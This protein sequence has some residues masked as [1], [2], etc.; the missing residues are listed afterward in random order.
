M[1]GFRP[2]V[3][4]F[5]FA[6]PFLV[7]SLSCNGEST[8]ADAAPDDG[9]PP[10]SIGLTMADIEVKLFQGNK[11]KTCHVRVSPGGPLPLYP[12]NFDIGSPGLAERVVD[13]MSDTSNGK[14]QC[15]GQVL[16]PKNDPLGSLFV[17][18]V[19]PQ[20]ATGMPRCGVRMPQALPKLNADEISCVKRWAVLAVKSVP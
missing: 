17:E 13:K 20:T 2:L 3:R 11:C 5:L 19:D 8:P 15:G 10:C 6:F 9:M 18:K 4:A 16:L 14:S 12:T 1:P 7:A